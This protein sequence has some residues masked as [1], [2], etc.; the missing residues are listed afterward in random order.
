MRGCVYSVCV[1]GGGGGGGG[2]CIF[3]QKR[4]ICDYN[5]RFVLWEDIGKFY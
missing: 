2:C 4:H 1:W 3:Y 5:D